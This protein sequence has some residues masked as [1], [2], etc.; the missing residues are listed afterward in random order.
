MT[1]F[2]SH[3]SID[4]ADAYGLSEFWKGVL[5]YVDVD[6]DPNEPG[7]E[8]CMILDQDAGHR[9]LFIE[10]AEGKTVKNRMHLDLRPR[11]G[12][13]DEEVARLLVLGAT[14]LADRRGVHGPGTGWVVLADPEGNEFCVLRSYRQIQA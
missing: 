6:D 2:V 4:C 5:C 7:D 13:R 10:V 9:L 8:E 1:S 14:E 3:T 12:T 11:T